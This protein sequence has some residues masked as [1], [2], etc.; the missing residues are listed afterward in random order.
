VRHCHLQ[1]DFSVD[2][3]NGLFLANFRKVPKILLS[4][5]DP[6]TS[7]RYITKTLRWISSFLRQSLVLARRYRNIEFDLPESNAKNARL[8]VFCKS[9]SPFRVTPLSM[10]KK[11]QLA[12]SF[13]S[14]GTFPPSLATKTRTADFWRFFWKYRK[15]YVGNG[16]QIDPKTSNRHISG[17]VRDIATTF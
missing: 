13:S 5:T 8:R 12:D 14:R 11:L 17:T 3:L 9:V 7:N 1:V 6:E 16:F 10:A 4:E 15:W 2:S